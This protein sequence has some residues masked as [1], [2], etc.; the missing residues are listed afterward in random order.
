[1]FTTTEP[2]DGRGCGERDG[3][4][5]YACCG[6]SEDGTPI[7][8]YVVDPAIPWPGEFQR[9][10]K[11]LPR[12]PKDPESIND[13]VIFVG[14]KFYESPWDFV[15]EARRFGAS[16]KL[17]HNLPFD[18]LSPDE[19]RMIFV[20]SR[21]IPDFDYECYR[22]RPYYGCS[23]FWTAQGEAQGEGKYDKATWEEAVPGW[24][25]H[26]LQQPCTH[27][28]RD[29]AFLVHGDIEPDPTNVTS[30]VIYQVNM[31]SFSY[32]AKYPVSPNYRAIKG[33]WGVGI[34][35]ALPLT[36][37]EYCRQAD[38]GSQPKAEAAGFKTVVMEH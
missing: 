17:P 25:Y 13:L 36:H 19:S 5:P 9:G 11:I 30:N 20:H 12:N 3:G 34:F 6:F 22:E 24:H 7:E 10:V 4:I 14:K 23:C 37:I 26:Q 28:L 29:L 2:P 32:Q 8:F 18:Q 16:R 1:M 21:A 35:M 38:E 33:D 27:A 31:P 15:E